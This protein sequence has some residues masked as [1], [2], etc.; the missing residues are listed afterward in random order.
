[1]S[2]YFGYAGRILR[3]NLTKNK[4]RV[5][6]TEKRLIMEFVG[7]RGFNSKRL[8]KEVPRSVA[9]L[10]PENKL[11]FATGPLVGTAFPLGARF[12]VSAKSPLTGILGDSNAGGA[13][14]RRNQVRRVRSNNN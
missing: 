3:V 12:N 14:C 9:P 4:I 2:K 11:M 8:Y 5:K 13:F 7:G 6:P 1:M 10:S